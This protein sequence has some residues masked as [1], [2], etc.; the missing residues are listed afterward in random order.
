[1]AAYVLALAQLLTL[2]GPV[3]TLPPEQMTPTQTSD[4]IQAVREEP[5]P[6]LIYHHNSYLWDAAGKRGHAHFQAINDVFWTG[7]SR[8]TRRLITALC[9]AFEKRAFG[10]VMLSRTNW[11]DVV[12]GLDVLSVSN[13]FHRNYELNRTV[14][15]GPREHSSAYLFRARPDPPRLGAA[16]AR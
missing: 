2:G 6:V 12:A 14:V 15:A 13:S 9:D 7:E 3:V 4:F 1:M 8:E 11:A 16:K 10:A 5:G